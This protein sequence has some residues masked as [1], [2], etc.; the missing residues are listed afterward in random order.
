MAGLLVIVIVGTLVRVAGINRTLDEIH[1]MQAIMPR[2]KNEWV[3]QI[4]ILDG[5]SSDGTIEWSR[6]NGGGG[7]VTP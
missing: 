4:I 2:V 5:G 6:E 3:D 7:V 1:G